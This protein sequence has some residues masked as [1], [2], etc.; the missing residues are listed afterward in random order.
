MIT[1]GRLLCLV[2]DWRL[3]AGGDLTAGLTDLLQGDDR[4]GV[5]IPPP[6]HVDV[7]LQPHPEV[8]LCRVLHHSVHIGATGSPQ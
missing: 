1:F 6:R 5:D 4:H 8:V 2:D 3:G 7:V